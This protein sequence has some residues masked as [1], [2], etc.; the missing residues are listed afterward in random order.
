MPTE[1]GYGPWKE[2]LTCKSCRIKLSSQFVHSICPY[3]GDSYPEEIV[4]AR[5][6]YK[7]KSPW[8]KFWKR[9]VY[10]WEFYD[11]QKKTEKPKVVIPKGKRKWSTRK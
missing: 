9:S 11:Q 3:C 6:A 8:W 4:T 1:I 5:K 10:D 7:Y 2:I